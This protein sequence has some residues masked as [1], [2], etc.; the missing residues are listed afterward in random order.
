MHRQNRWKHGPL[1]TDKPV[2]FRD[3]VGRHA[4]RAKDFLRRAIRFMARIA[5][6]HVGRVIA[7]R[8]KALLRVRRVQGVAFVP[9]Q[10]IYAQLFVEP[11]QMVKGPVF[12]HEHNNCGSPQKR[13]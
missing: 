9:M 1:R 10:A 7:D 2:H 4:R 5:R 8:H 6:P 12:F 11:K 3:V 13:D